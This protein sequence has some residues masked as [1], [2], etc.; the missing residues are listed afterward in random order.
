MEAETRFPGNTVL[1]I[2]FPVEPKK[3]FATYHRG[4]SLRIRGEK[5][6]S[7]TTRAVIGQF[8]G[9]CSTRRVVPSLLHSPRIQQ[10]RIK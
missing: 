8:S 2:F 5:Y 4:F 3:T 1:P 10:V 9:P 6:L 7:V